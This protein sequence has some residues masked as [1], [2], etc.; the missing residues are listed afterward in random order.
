VLLEV[1]QLDGGLIG[2]YAIIAPTED[3]R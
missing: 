3:K 2:K 1:M